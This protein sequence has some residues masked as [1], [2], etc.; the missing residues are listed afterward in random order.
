MMEKKRRANTR[1]GEREKKGA[2]KRKVV[3]RGR[4]R[5]SDEAKEEEKEEPGHGAKATRRGT[6]RPDTDAHR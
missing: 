3:G 1:S 5:A 6:A 4:K 2:A